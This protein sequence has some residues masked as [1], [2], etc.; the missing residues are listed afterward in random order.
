MV[1]PSIAR[2]VGVLNLV[3][4]CARHNLASE[5]LPRPDLHPH[6]LPIIRCGIVRH[7]DRVVDQR[8]SLASRAR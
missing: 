8:L 3:A 6:D 4:V 2:G 1:T 7:F 5:P